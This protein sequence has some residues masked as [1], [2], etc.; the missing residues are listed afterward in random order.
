MDEDKKKKVIALKKA[1]SHIKKIIEMV[2]N[3]AKCL[4]TLQQIKAVV[5]ILKGVQTGVMEC[6]LEECFA[7]S[8][9]LKDSEKQKDLVKNISKVVNLL[10]K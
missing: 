5:G 4:D 2:E 7:E 6:H 9:K 3:D 1:N 8:S 10:N